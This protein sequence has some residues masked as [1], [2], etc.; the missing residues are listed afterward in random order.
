MRSYTGEKID[1]RQEGFVILIG[2]RLSALAVVAAG[3]AWMID[4]QWLTWAS[5]PIPGWLRW[6]GAILATAGGCLWVWAVH[7]LGRNLTDTV[8]TRKEHTLVTSGPYR[9]IRHPFY[10]ACA[11]G[12]VGGSLVMANWLLPLLAVIVWFAFLVPRTTIE[13]RHLLARFG[14]GYRDYLQRTGRFLPRRRS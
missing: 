5:W 9:W 8:I 11:V 1:R 3:A 7:S 14:D 2:L 10:A 6:C 12:L 13:E 4:P